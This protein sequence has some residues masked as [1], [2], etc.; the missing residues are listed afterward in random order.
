MVVQLLIE[1]EPR[2]IVRYQESR[3]AAGAARRTVNMEIGL[4]RQIMRKHGAWNRVRPDVAMLAERQD[5]GRALAAEEERVLLFGCA[6][7]RGRL[8][9]PFTV[10]AL[11]TGARRNSIRILQWANIDFT[12]RCLKFGKDKTPAGTGRTV[13]LNPRALETLKFW[14][15]QSPNRQP[16]RSV[17][18]A[19]K[20]GAAGNAFDAEVYAT[21]P[22]K[23]IANFKEAWEAERDKYGATARS[24]MARSAMAC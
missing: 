1:I 6:R 9:L 3:L 24:A 23:P 18:P 10:L 15:Q 4:L 20:V 8:L 5:V 7:S 14:A 12:N 13:P 22:A 21:D 16:E 19:E 2:H 17:F 11:E